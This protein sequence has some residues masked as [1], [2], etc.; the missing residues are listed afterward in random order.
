MGKLVLVTGGARSGK[1][2]F[3]EAEVRKLN[4]K[5]AYIATGIAFD[6]AMKSRIEKHVAQRPSIWTTYEKPTQVHEIVKEVSQQ[7]N[8]VLLDCI[9]VLITNT[10]F[11][12]QIDFDGIDE[13]TVDL[14]EE[15]IHND[16]KMMVEMFRKTDMTVYL[17]TN[18]VG[19]GIVPENRL[20]RIFR[21]FAGRTNQYIASIADEV[22]CVISGIPVKIKG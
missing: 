5:T 4:Q 10:L 3:A 14:T 6:E 20:A 21:D 2:T 16:I 18:E 13:K 12:D 19:S 17:V 9:T 11:Q 7:H 22:Y 15:R 8:V 1:S